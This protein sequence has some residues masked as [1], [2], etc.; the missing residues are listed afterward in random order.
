LRLHPLQ[1][2]RREKRGGENNIRRVE[3]VKK[4]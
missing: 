4:N 1:E 3:E 2:E